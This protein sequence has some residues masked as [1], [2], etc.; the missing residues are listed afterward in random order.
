[1]TL[2]VRELTDAEQDAAH[3]LRNQAFGVRRE[4]RDP[5]R[6][7]RDPER[8]VVLGAFDGDRLVGTATAF[9]TGQ[10][11][12]RRSVPTGGV[13]GVATTP[14]VRGS[15]AGTRVM[16]A[17]LGEMRARGLAMATL[18]PATTAFYRR[19][20]WEAAGTWHRV[21]L[22]SRSLADLVHPPDVT[23]RPTTF[24]E[25]PE[26]RGCYD[27]A[28]PTR[29]GWLDRD[30]THWRYLRWQ[31]E[32]EEG[33]QRHLYLAERDARTVGFVSYHHVEEDPRFYGL[34]IDGLVAH[35]RDAFAALL[36]LLGSNR[37]V[38]DRVA[39]R[40][41]DVDALVLVLPEP[42]AE[43]TSAWHW[44]TRFVDVAAAIAA[45]GYPPG[46]DAAVDLQLEDQ[47]APWHTGRWRLVV[48]EGRAELESGGEGR[49]QLD[50][51]AFA[52]LYTGWASPW[53]L[54]RLGRIGGATEGDLDALSAAFSGPRPWLPDFF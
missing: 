44:M 53:E 25:V 12:G 13:A 5:D 34:Q 10:W 24:V 40:G 17:L 47:H 22:P 6:P 54:V 46:V 36:R 49:V 39:W 15:G 50:A 41:A 30:D 32:R 42:D 7:E 45:R 43:I 11:F 9:A 20:G 18:Y 8:D 26:L 2:A 48:S 35:D 3:A 51:G 16:L 19:L 52:S 4:A 1:V 31:F 28:A 29:A 27:T 14:D 33:P 38:T 23:V 37:S 21:A